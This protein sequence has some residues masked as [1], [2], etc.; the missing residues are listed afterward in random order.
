MNKIN[1]I[2]LDGGFLVFYSAIQ[3]ERLVM[4]NKIQYKK[5]DYKQL[6]EFYKQRVQQI[7][8]VGEYAHL[9]KKDEAHARYFVKDY[10]NVE[11]TKFMQKYF[12]YER[13]PEIN[14]NI[15]PGKYSKLFG[16]LSPRQREII[17]DDDSKY[18]VVAAGPGSGKT[19]VLVHKLAS[20]LLLE[21]V[22]SEQLLMLTFSRS[23]ATEFKKRLYEL[24]GEV[25]FLC[26][27]Q[28]FPFILF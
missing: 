19:K 12:N 16:D 11:Y 5:E 21:D 6:N 10:F 17:D 22:K 3:V 20:L 18:I 13:A 8:I 26:G 15:T 14:R 28:D 1:A 24:I 27:N 2:E 23:A 25:S 7:H 9:M 4:D